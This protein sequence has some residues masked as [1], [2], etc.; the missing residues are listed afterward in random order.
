[1]ITPAIVLRR[2]AVDEARRRPASSAWFAE[3]GIREEPV[4]GQAVQEGK[5]IGAFV[6]GQ[7]K[8][9]ALYA[10]RQ[11]ADAPNRAGSRLSKTVATEISTCVNRQ[12]R[13]FRRET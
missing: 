3:R 12:P 7:R 2:R 6:S 10:L 9:R 4:I 13:I 1:M 8:A 5:K 11:P